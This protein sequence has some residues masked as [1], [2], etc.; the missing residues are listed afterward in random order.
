MKKIF[1]ILVLVV[2]SAFTFVL[3]PPQNIRSDLLGWEKNSSQMWAYVGWDWEDVVG[4]R[5]YDIEIEGLGYVYRVVGSWYVHYTYVQ[6][7]PTTYR[8]RV[9]TVD[10]DHSV[11]DWS[12]WVP[13]TVCVSGKGKNGSAWIC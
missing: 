8:A 9:R 7:S 4:A 3:P 2:I 6:Q 5:E 12:P 11:G 13:I 10:Q 1:G